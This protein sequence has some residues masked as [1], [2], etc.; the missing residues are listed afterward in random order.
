MAPLA[1]IA[2]SQ[3]A[4]YSL[5]PP[6]TA[7]HASHRRTSPRAAATPPHATS[8]RCTRASRALARAQV[9]TGPPLISWTA[10]VR[11]AG[12]RD[13]TK[14]AAAAAKAG[15]STAK[16]GGAAPP[17]PAA[18]SN[19]ARA[20]VATAATAATAATS[21]APVVAR[22]SPPVAWAPGGPRPSQGA[23]SAPSALRVRRGSSDGAEGAPSAPRMIR[24]SRGRSQGTE[25]APRAPRGRPEGADR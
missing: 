15:N 14:A 5:T 3:G 12:P 19:V 4:S 25:S 1:L 24:R 2:C 13:P 22:A 20:A 7:S 8:H 18:A 21:R 9:A 10:P 6:H 17:R 11:L 16:A 23:P